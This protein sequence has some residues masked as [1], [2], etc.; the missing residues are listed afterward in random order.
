MQLPQYKTSGWSYLKWVIIAVIIGLF[1]YAAYAYL[2]HVEPGYT[3]VAGLLSGITT[4]NFGGFLTDIWTWITQ[5][6]ALVGAMVTASVFILGWLRERAQKNQVAEQAQLL[7]SQTE[8][9]ITGLVD[10]NKKLAAQVQT[11]QTNVSGSA[12]DTYESTIQTLT[13]QK[14]QLEATVQSQVRTIQELKETLAIAAAKKVE[15]PVY[16]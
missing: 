6:T 13:G 10:D 12:Y 11:L 5:N 3:W 9:Q 4:F 15:V 14:N 8:N 16:K 7:Q 2:T 1:A